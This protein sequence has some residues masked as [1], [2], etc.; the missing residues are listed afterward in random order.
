MVD[1]LHLQAISIYFLLVEDRN[2]FTG[3]HLSNGI[4]YTS[5]FIN[6]FRIKES[7]NVLLNLIGF[8]KIH[9]GSI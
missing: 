5:C 1:I 2:L 6:K 8:G 3:H 9:M 7:Q 4:Y